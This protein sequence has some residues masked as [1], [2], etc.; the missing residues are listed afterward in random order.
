MKGNDN[1]ILQSFLL[2]FFLAP[3]YVIFSCNAKS[4]RLHCEIHSSK[5]NIDKKHHHVF[6]A[7]FD[8]FSSFLLN[9]NYS[10]SA[11]TLNLLMQEPRSKCRFTGYL[12]QCILLHT[13]KLVLKSKNI[14]RIGW[15]WEPNFLIRY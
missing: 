10:L 15:R 2:L 7:L 14:L 9:F 8:C 11:V 4:G 5:K 1:Q 12:V 6:E 3:S 13:L